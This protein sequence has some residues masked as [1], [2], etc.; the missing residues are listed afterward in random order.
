MVESVTKG[1]VRSRLKELVLKREVALGKRIKQGEIAQYTG[2][3]PNTVS[4]WM[5][6]KPMARIELDAAMKF[7]AWLGC[8][9]GDLVYIDW[10]GGKEK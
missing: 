9:L 1:V 6:P 7:C 8:E 2:V 4:R 10:D 5:S 3:N